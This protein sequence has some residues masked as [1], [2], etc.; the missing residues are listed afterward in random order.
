MLTL[1]ADVR[2][3]DFAN[4]NENHLQENLLMHNSIEIEILNLIDE[5]LIGLDNARKAFS[6]WNATQS[7]DLPLRRQ[8]WQAKKNNAN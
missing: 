8:Q 1:N 6:E 3:N 4:L 2:W 7:E 5:T